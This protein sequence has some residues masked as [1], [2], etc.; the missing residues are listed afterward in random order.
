MSNG[1][2]MVIT[3]ALNGSESKSLASKFNSGRFDKSMKWA[4]E[5]S[6]AMQAF[7]KNEQLQRCSMESIQNAMLDVAYSGLTLAPSLAH[8]YL[9]PYGNVCTFSPGYRGLMHM[10]FKAGTVK[11]IQVNLA[12]R[13]DP[14]FRVST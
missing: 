9:I 11:S 10:G 13:Q 12:Y 3:T 14:T 4:A 1:Q 5:R 2:L 8:G 6:F 7:K